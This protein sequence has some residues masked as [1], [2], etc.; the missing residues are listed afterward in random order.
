MEKSARIYVRGD[1]NKGIQAVWLEEAARQC[2]KCGERDRWR[3][4]SCESCG[5]HQTAFLVC[6][7]CNTRLEDRDVEYEARSSSGN[8]YTKSLPGDW[9]PTCST[10][11]VYRM[12]A[13]HLDEFIEGV[14]HDLQVIPEVG[15]QTSDVLEV[16]VSSTCEDV[17]TSS[18]YEIESTAIPGLRVEVGP[19]SELF[20]KC[21]EEITSYDT[22]DY[23]HDL[24]QTLRIYPGPSYGTD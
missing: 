22:G 23:G 3:A 7:K 11:Y 20:E 24:S 1:F 10:V 8:R 18:E 13:D 15:I 12:F 9:C 6:T 14:P 16:F 19:Q 21:V 4:G 2:R 17:G 5:T